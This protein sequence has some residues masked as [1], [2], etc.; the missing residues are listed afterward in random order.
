MVDLSTL[1]EEARQAVERLGSVDIV[2]GIPS[3]EDGGRIETV[4]R[5]VSAGLAERCGQYRSAIIHADG[6]LAGGSRKRL[7]ALSLEDTPLIRVPYELSLVHRLSAPYHGMPGRD[8]AFRVILTLAQ[9]V[10]SHSSGSVGRLLG[11]VLQDGYDF[12]APRYHRHRFDGTIVT[13]I[14]Y[15]FT[16]ALYGK[17]IRQPL[18]DDFGLSG[19]LVGDYLRQPVWDTDV[20]RFAL[21]LWITT[22]AT[23][24][25]FRVCQAYLGARAHAARDPAIDL[26]TMLSQILDPL[27]TDMDRN[28][29]VWQRIRGSEPVPTF[30]DPLDVDAAP[31]SANLQRMRESFRLGYQ[32]LDEVWSQILPP[33]TMLDLKRLSRASDRDLLFPDELW[34]RVLYDFAL[35]HHLRVMA[36]EHLLGALTPLYLGW[37]ASFVTQTESAGADEVD[38]QVERLCQAFES[39]KRYLISRWRWPDR[40]NP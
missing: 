30:G 20:A 5:A 3:D 8:V 37:V 32:T 34:A 22:R 16:R 6:G 26:S 18:G 21:N 12:V 31:V 1:P 17:R 28:N 7:P 14:V 9:D 4:A 33:T 10:G 39:E 23:C 36:R 27:F 19:R 35:G 2:V 38:A 25:G 13:G 11:P 24:G 15:P 29:A 40:F